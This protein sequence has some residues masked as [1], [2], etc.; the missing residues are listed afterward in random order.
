M[1]DVID[2]EYRPDSYFRPLKLERYMLSKVK[3][4]VVRRRLQAL[5]D[6]G[7]HDDVMSLLTSDG[8]SEADRKA[9]ELS[10]PMFMG[11]NYLPDT[12]RGE[13]EIARISIDSTTHDVTCIYA[14][15]GKRFI[16]FR[17]VDEYEGDTLRGKTKRWRKQP[18]TLGELTD[19]FLSVWP[20]FDVLRMNFDDDCEAAL[21]FFRAE[22]QFYPNFDRLCRWRVA[23]K[24]PEN[25][26]VLGAERSDV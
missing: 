8:I 26:N 25:P 18:M 2:L 15:R 1:S 20:L 16:H 3:G 24:F 4:A 7:R 13:V 5:F 14:R 23:E 6:A 19:Y 10:H 9:L 11:G 17:V 21:E 22:S 12:G